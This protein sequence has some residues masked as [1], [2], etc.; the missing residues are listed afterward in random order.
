MSY[1]NALPPQSIAAHDLARLN[2]SML[3]AL[4]SSHPQLPAV[5]GDAEYA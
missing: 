4:R 2:E 1:A 5:L 3:D